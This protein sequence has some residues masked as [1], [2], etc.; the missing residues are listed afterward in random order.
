LP[1][2]SLPAIATR[3]QAAALTPAAIAAERRSRAEA[4]DGRAA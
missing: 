4:N 3:E 1:G 2:I